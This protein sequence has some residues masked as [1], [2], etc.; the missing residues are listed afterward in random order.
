[1]WM[2][3]TT[4]SDC[5]ERLVP[6]WLGLFPFMEQG[7]IFNAFNFSYS[8]GGNGLVQNSTSAYT[9]VNSLICPSDLPTTSKVSGSGNIYSQCSYAA[10]V[11]NGDIFRWYYGC[12]LGAGNPSVWIAPDGPFGI[13][14]TY[15]VADIM[16]GTSNTIFVGEQNRFKQDPDTVFQAW[17]RT[18]WFGS[19]AAG[20]TRLN[21]WATTV[22]AINAAFL[23][24]DAPSDS[25]YYNQWY[26]NAA[27][28]SVNLT[29]GQFGFRSQHPGGANFVFGDGSVHFLKSTIQT[30]G[31]VLANGQLSLGVFRKLGT[32]AGNEVVSADAY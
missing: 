1:M 14:L 4:T 29:F 23:Y 16:D 13:D 25:S 26:L 7:L 20:S 31:P 32:R 24:G 8:A 12:P 21:G 30:A 19:N 10:S 27:T 28:S 22:P 3:E 11:G 5:V 15:K 17:T 9:T 2:Q 6:M 18:A